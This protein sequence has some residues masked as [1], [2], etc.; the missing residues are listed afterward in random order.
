MG[1]HLTHWRS[2]IIWGI[3]LDGVE[4][5]GRDGRTKERTKQFRTQRQSDMLYMWW[6]MKQGPKCGFSLRR[7]DHPNGFADWIFC[8]NFNFF[9]RG[10]LLIFTKNHLWLSSEIKFQRNGRHAWATYRF[11]QRFESILIVI[12]IGVIRIVVIRIV[13]IRIVVIRSA[14]KQIF[15][16]RQP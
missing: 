8:Q 2:H 12:R 15:T 16:W 9:H 5:W 11:Q 14:Q 10:K 7:V 13:V 3:M 6:W 1:E 4:M